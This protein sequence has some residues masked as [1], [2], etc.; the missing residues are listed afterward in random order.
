MH[1]N[2]L[3]MAG[4]LNSRFAKHYIAPSKQKCSHKISCS[5]QIEN[6]VSK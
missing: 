4:G 2:M 5:L 3:K 1:N 6:T